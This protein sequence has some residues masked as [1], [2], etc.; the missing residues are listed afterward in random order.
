M[1][2]VINALMAAVVI[3]VGPSSVMAEGL[4]WGPLTGKVSVT[5]ADTHAAMDA[6]CS[7]SQDAGMSTPDV[8]GGPGST[9]VGGTSALTFDRSKLTPGNDNFDAYFSCNGSGCAIAFDVSGWTA[10]ALTPPIDADVLVRFVA[11]AYHELAHVA[12]QQYFS[13]W[14]ASHSSAC[15]DFQ[16]CIQTLTDSEGNNLGY[17]AQNNPCSEA[18]ANGKEAV[19]ALPRQAGHLRQW[20]HESC[21][22]GGAPRGAGCRNRLRQ[23]QLPPTN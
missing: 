3:L 10:L 1:S 17:N 22:Q 15:S 7:A 13:G 21:D 2:I 14:C 11:S 18:Y 5:T 4:N 23:E 12:Y 9:T 6:I 16:D 19:E 20:D 8:A